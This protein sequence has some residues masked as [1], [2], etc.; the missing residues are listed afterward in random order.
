MAGDDFHSIE[1]EAARRCGGTVALEAALVRPEPPESLAMVGDDRYLSAMSRRIFRAGLKHSLVD[2]RWPAFEAAFN[3]FDPETV[4][5]MDDA[6]L[7]D[8]ATDERL[9]RHRAKIRAVR[10]N[11]RAMRSLADEFGSMGN[12]LAAWPD[13]EIVELWAALRHRFTQLG[14]RSSPAFLRM[15]GKD[16]FLLTDWVIKALR[17]W[18]GYDGGTRSKRDLQA[19]QA[20]FNAWSERSG[21]PLCQI[22]QILAY[23][24]D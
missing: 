17:Q 16:T 14:G 22:S 18:G 10:A 1:A 7:N 8:R 19:V 6:E 11:A 4:A 12:W 3:D 20:R 9:I 13:E 5:S 15:V 23:S 2:A 21:R 24:V